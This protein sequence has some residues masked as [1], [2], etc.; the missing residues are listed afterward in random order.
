M[1]CLTGRGLQTCVNVVKAIVINEF[2]GPEVFR[3]AEVEM[4]MPGEGEVLIRV[5]ASSVNPVDTK[6]RSG[7]LE[8]IAPP[9][10]AILHGD[11]AGVVESVGVGVTGL[12]PGDTVYACAGGFKGLPGSLAEFVLADAALV[13]RRPANLTAR[14]A[15]VLPLAGITAWDALHDRG[16]VAAGMR[17]L[18]HA[19][20]GGVGHL[21]VQLAKAAGAEVTT[22]VSTLTKAEL[23][24]ELGADHVVLYPEQSVED[25]VQAYT[26]GE[27]FDLVF[28]TVGDA[29]LQNSFAAMRLQGRVVSIAAR[30]EQD[31]T[32]LHTRAGTLS[33]TFM[34]LPLITGQGRAR[35]G[36]ILRELTDLVEVGKVRPLLDQSAFS[37]EEVAQAHAKLESGRAVGKI[38]LAW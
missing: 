24:R 38:S 35:H 18:V 27:G 1:R 28:D 6:I 30:S 16:Q 31:L 4:H 26:G 13:A 33:V 25:Y 11:V 2:G 14:A 8:A 3:A 36:E 17:V 37:I 20:C 21:G 10:P 19:G 15:G 7:V 5:E 23:A 12:A 32:A 29:N 9:F 22:T 34:L